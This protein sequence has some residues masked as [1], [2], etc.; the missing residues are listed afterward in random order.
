MK[1]DPA[2][3]ELAEAFIDDPP[4]KSRLLKIG[5]SLDEL[6]VQRRRLAQ[7]I[8]DA[9]EDWFTLF[10]AELEDRSAELGSRK[11]L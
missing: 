1:Y 2:C 3:E 7:V 11:D 9:I 8:Q 6:A 10:E 5:L 4:E